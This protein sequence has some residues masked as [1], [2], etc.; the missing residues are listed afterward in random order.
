MV[1]QNIMMTLIAQW[2]Q[3][4]LDYLQNRGLFTH[5]IEHLMNSQAWIISEC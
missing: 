4:L 3:Q 5:H 1:K 2:L